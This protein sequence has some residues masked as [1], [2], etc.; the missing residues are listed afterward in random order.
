MPLDS[1]AVANEELLGGEALNQE[2]PAR[3]N[4]PGSSLEEEAQPGACGVPL[5]LESSECKW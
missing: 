3:E 2:H 1:P 5:L 4:G